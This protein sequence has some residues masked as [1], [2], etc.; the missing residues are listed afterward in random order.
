MWLDDAIEKAG[1]PIEVDVTEVA[2]PADSIQVI[3]LSAS[4]YNTLKAHPDLRGAAGE[5]RAEL[6]GLLMV[7]EMMTK[8]DSTITWA[9][10]KRLPLSTLGALAGAISEAVGNPTEGALGE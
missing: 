5:D 2:I 4:E 9:K 7:A 8:A 6:L 1:S 3:P 10:L